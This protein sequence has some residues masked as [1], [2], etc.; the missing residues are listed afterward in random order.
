[1]VWRSTYHKI[2]AQIADVVTTIL[3][4]FGAYG[5]W[6]ALRWLAPGLSLGSDIV[7]DSSFFIFIV[8]TSAVWV[9]LFDLQGAYSY[10]RFTSFSKEIKFLTK[11][12][13]WGIFILLGLLFLARPGYIPRTLVIIFGVVNFIFLTLEKFF[14]FYVAKIIRAQGRNRKTILIV[15]GGNQTQR[16][17]ETI[18]KNFSWGLDIVGLL[19]ADQANVG[20]NLFGNTVIGTYKDITTIL[21]EHP[22]DEVIITISSRRMG[23]IRNVL[24]ACELEGVRVRII[25]D[26]LGEIAKK[27]RAD[28][29]YGLPVISISY[30]PEKRMPLFI[31]RCIDVVGS[32]LLIIAFAP[33]FLI[34]AFAIKLSQPGPVLYEWNVVGFNKKPFRSWKFRTMVVNADA[35]KERLLHLNEMEGPVFK[36]KNDPRITPIGRFLRKYSLDELP[37]LWSVLKGDMSLVGPRPAFKDELRRYDNWQRRKLSIKPGITCLWQINGRSEINNF[38][39]WAKMDLDY[40]DN[41]SLRLDCKILLKTIPAVILG[42]GAS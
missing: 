34:I 19:T 7:I 21:H 20:K 25:S 40:I 30:I 41:W 24:D 5:L 3:S 2:L 11:T 13:C 23:E 1:M 16:F 18:R 42:R 12:V 31:K 22:L 28:V 4:F 39:N 33:L 9:V 17:I 8:V 38:D 10:Q 27:I 26:F 35:E 29:I 36:I 37:Q 14:M 15:G 6:R 32:L